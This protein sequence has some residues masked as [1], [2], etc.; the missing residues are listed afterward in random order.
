MTCASA[1]VPLGLGSGVLARTGELDQAKGK[2]K[3]GMA[4]AKDRVDDV[5]KDLTD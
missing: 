1:F 4:D 2:A 3:Q 5:V